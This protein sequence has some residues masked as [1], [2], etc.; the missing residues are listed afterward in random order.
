MLYPRGLQTTAREAVVYGYRN[1]AIGLD[2]KS[3]HEIHIQFVFENLRFGTPISNPI[4]TPPTQ[5][6]VSQ[7][8]C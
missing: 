3:F 2:P 1:F 4:P 7:N 5:L 8:I 6:D